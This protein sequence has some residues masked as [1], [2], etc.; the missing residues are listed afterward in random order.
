MDQKKVSPEEINA[1]LPQ[2]QCRQCGF[3]GCANY[4]RAI[5]EGGA[6][7]NR[8][9]PGGARGI[10]ALASA[11]NIP[12]LPLDPDYGTEKPLALA[13]IDLTRC[14]GCHLCLAACPVDAITGVPK[15]LFSVI[16]SDCTGCA[17]CTPACPMDAIQMKEV[18][19][20]WNTFDAKKAR[21]NYE[22]SLQRKEK[23]K[24][25]LNENY[26]H[27]SDRK[28]SILAYALAQARKEK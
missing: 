26:A 16:E 12:V 5:A 21:E 6:P 10:A 17:L 2:T 27:L 18:D 15:H 11:L 28:A 4:A 14:I 9:A 23:E 3:D 8:C 22:R 1:L 25:R 13:H 24:A 20:V 19:H 7:I